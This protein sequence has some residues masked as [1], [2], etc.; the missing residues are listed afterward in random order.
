MGGKAVFLSHANLLKDRPQSSVC[1]V[2]C[3]SIEEACLCIE[4]FNK[5]N[6]LGLIM[7]LDPKERFDAERL[8]ET[9]C[10]HKYSRTGVKS[11]VK[12]YFPQ[13]GFSD[14][15]MTSVKNFTKGDADKAYMVFLYLKARSDIVSGNFLKLIPERYLESVYAQGVDLFARYLLGGQGVLTLILFDRVNGLELLTTACIMNYAQ[16][17]Y[18]YAETVI[19]QGN[20]DVF[21]D[22]T[23]Y[24]Y[25]NRPKNR[26]AFMFITE[27]CRLTLNFMNEYEDKQEP[28]FIVLVLNIM[29]FLDAEDG[30]GAVKYDAIRG[31]LKGLEGLVKA[32]ESTR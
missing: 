3:S 24:L 27:L 25:L 20:A 32:Y 10:Y 7:F 6:M 16:S 9:G 23:D 30:S 5:I 18:E 21:E 2:D 22:R 17:Q 13:A 11:V 31:L 28:A 29:R 26:K 8:K 14:N 1:V 15:V 4:I 12:Y 19:R